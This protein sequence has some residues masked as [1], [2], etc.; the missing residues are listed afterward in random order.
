MR[1]QVT[2]AVG[3]A[4]ITLAL[5]LGTFIAGNEPF[6]G[7]DLQGGASVVFEPTTDVDGG[8]LDQ[9]IDIMNQRVNDF[10]AREP[11]IYEQGGSIVVELPGIDDQD[12]ALALVGQTAELLFRAVL[13]T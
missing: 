13:S 8:R 5:P 12:Q 7:L 9:A 1:R 4:V 10:G 11:E 6:L 2:F 3:T